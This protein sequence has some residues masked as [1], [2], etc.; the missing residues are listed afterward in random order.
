MAGGTL[1]STE[2][3]FTVRVPELRSSTTLAVTRCE[4]RGKAVLCLDNAFSLIEGHPRNRQ[5]PDE[6]LADVSAAA[7]SFRR[8]ACWR[9]SCGSVLVG[10]VYLSKLALALTD[11]LQEILD[12]FDGLCLRVCPE[13][14]EAADHFLGLGE[15]PI[16]HGQLPAREANAGPESAWQAALGSD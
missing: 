5:G 13:D 11:Y 10:F 7:S 16:G 12:H 6:T 9:R 1:C 14:G 15:R 2:K 8:S 3:G 4:K